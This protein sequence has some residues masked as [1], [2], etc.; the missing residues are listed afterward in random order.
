MEGD[1]GLTH[2]DNNC[3]WTGG[4]I[5]S[6]KSLPDQCGGICIATSGCTRFNWRSGTC[7]VKGSGGELVTGQG[8]PI[9]I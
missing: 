8:K 5:N 7:Y 9:I 1:G 2:W 3:Y 6:K 4:D